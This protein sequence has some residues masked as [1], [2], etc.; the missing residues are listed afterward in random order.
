MT[1]MTS[2]ECLNLPIQNKILLHMFECSFVKPIGL[3]HILV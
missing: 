1:L 2:Y 3:D